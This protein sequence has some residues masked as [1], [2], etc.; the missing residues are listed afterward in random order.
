M[1]Y[2]IWGRMSGNGQS[3]QIALGNRQRW[4]A[5]GGMAPARCRQIMA[6]KN[7]RIWRFFILALGVFPTNCSG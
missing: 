6:L 3:L 5:H 1:G 2:M 4:G 7:H